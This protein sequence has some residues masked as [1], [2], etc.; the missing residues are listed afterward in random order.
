MAEVI[1]TDDNFEAEVIHS[2]VPVLVDFWA[3]WCGPCQMMGPIVESLANELDAGKVKIAKINVDDHKMAA[4]KY[5][6]MSIPNFILFKNGEVAD[7]IAGGMQ[8]EKLKE[9]I[10]KHI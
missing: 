2:S 9:F 6:V 4:G 1:L 7:Q 5:N 3:P 8:K 10:E